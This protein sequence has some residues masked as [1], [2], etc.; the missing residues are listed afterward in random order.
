LFGAT[1][2]VYCFNR[3]ARAVWFLLNKIMKIMALQFY[4]D[5]P[6]LDAKCLGPSTTAAATFL[7]DI[8]GFTYATEGD[9]NLGFD[10]VFSMLGIEVDLTNL[11]RGSLLVRN[12]PKRVT[13]VKAMIHSIIA[14]KTLLLHD[15]QSLRGKLQFM[16][17]QYLGR[18]FKPALLILDDFISSYQSKHELSPLLQAALSFVCQQLADA[19]P[20]EIRINQVLQPILVFTDGA[21]EPQS[22]GQY[23]A[24]YG[25]VLLDPVNDIRVV[26]DG[27]VPEPILKCWNKL[28]G[29]Q[30][31]GQVELYPVVALRIKYAS[32]FHNRRVLYFID[33]DS[34]RDALI[35][36]SSKSLASFVLVSMF[37]SFEARFPSYPWFNRVPSH[38]N[39]AD[40]PSRGEVELAVKLFNLKYDG[41]LFLPDECADQI[42]A[43]AD[44]SVMFPKVD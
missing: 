26:H 40:P 38:S 24:S 43:T 5:Y 1:S 12:K 32:L 44:M 2:S 17:G 41:P 11:P 30:L 35:R 25:A 16:Q 29:D 34:A 3:T 18:V 27:C 6:I 28:V 33:N 21:Y 13:D 23:L 15:A 7:L 42:V 22:T 14:A 31:I 4:D 36:G 37:F 9:K 8:L 39:P 20:R 10:K 19:E